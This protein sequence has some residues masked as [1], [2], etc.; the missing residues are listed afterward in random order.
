MNIELNDAELEILIDAL[1]RL[2]EV[3]AEALATVL[4]S[5][6]AEGQSVPFT[7]HDF[8]MPQITALLLRIEAAYAA[9]GEANDEP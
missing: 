8:G 9:N 4:A 1:N 7:E 2:H 5:G 3:K 6:I